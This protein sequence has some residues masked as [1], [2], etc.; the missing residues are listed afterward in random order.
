MSIN[1]ARMEDYVSVPEYF[2]TDI[3][4]LEDAGGG[5]CRMIRCIKRRGILL[6]VYSLVTPTLNMIQQSA[7]VHEAAVKILALYRSDH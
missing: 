3:G 4:L 6:P 5:N 1:D 7:A 2:A